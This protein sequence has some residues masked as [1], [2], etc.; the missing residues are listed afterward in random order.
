MSSGTIF[1]GPG[2]EFFKS[3]L[4]QSPFNYLEIGVFNGVSI[5]NLGAQY[6]DKTIYGVDPFIEDGCTTDHSGVVEHEFMSTQHANTMSN[7]EGLE[8]ITLFKMTSVE[9][10]STLTDA[11]ISDMDVG[12]V[13][14]DGSHHYPDVINDVHVAMRLIGD[15]KGGV[16]FDDLNIEGVK[17]A[18]DE[19]VSLYASKISEPTDL[20]HVHPGHILAYYINHE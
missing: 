15:R 8:N 20:Y 17:R 13:L 4:A 2:Y 11:M 1:C 6:P 19:F 7:I 12:W 10:N 14:I 3:Q 5:A 18:H 9:F 16:V